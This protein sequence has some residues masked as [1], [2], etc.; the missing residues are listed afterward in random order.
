MFA[1]IEASL[2]LLTPLCCCALVYM[3]HPLPLPLPLQQTV[4]G[5]LMLNQTCVCTLQAAALAVV[6]AFTQLLPSACWG[7]AVGPDS[8]VSQPQPPPPTH[9]PPPAILTHTCTPHHHHG[10]CVTTVSWYSLRGCS[11]PPLGARGDL[12]A[13]VSLFFVR[14]CAFVLVVAGRCWAGLGVS[15]N[16]T[17][18]DATVFIIGQACALLFVPSSLR[19]PR[20]PL[21][22]SS[23]TL[24][25]CGH[26]VECLPLCACRWVCAPQLDATGHASVALYQVADA[27]YGHAP[28]VVRAWRLCACVCAPD[29]H[30]CVAGAVRQ[31]RLCATHAHT[32]PPA[33]VLTPTLVL[34]IVHVASS[35]SSSCCC[36]CCRCCRCCCCTCSI[37]S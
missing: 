31:K 34:C 13:R 4:K 3:V 30:V 12:Q 9:P 36:R 16:G 20:T 19:T 28:P 15:A 21:T 7:R 24:P 11:Q 17:M 2:S 29:T 6:G 14:A 23:P 33:R 37:P 1:Q 18:G 27:P 25:R 5:E 32:R 8:Q 35:S 22:L 10:G 26:P